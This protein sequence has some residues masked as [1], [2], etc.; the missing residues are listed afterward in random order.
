VTGNVEK[1][2]LIIIDLFIEKRVPEK[3][4]SI[5]FWEKVKV[6]VRNNGS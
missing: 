6:K 4:F 5:E 1:F 2:D 3:L